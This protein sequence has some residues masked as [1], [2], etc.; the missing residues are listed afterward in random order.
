MKKI[1]TVKFSN[2]LLFSMVPF[3]NSPDIGYI[4][5][6]KAGVYVGSIDISSDIRALE[7]LASA[8]SGM[9]RRRRKP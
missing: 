6:E 9:V 1:S 8:L 7:K 4:R 2:D 5:I 3:E